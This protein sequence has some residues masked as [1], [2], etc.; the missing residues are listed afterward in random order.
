MVEIKPR[1][2][3]DGVGWCDA[4]C[5]RIN[6]IG[7][8]ANI[9]QCTIDEVTQED[10]VCPIHTARM[11]ALLRWLTNIGYGVGRRGGNPE[12]GEADDALQ[13]SRTLLRGE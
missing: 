13:Q 2:D 12:F 10:D 8:V 1:I 4:G 6:D 9:Y 3:G 7:V 11:A 5:P